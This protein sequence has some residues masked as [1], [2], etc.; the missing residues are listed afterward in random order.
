MDTF[1]EALTSRM[2]EGR[3]GEVGGE[4]GKRGQNEIHSWCLRTPGFKE[5]QRCTV[6][7]YL[8]IWKASHTRE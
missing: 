8:Y 1:S 3:V 2:K 6:H 4:T 5:T 7:L